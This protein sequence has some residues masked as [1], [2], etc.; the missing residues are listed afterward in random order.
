MDILEGLS[1][2]QKEAVQYGD[3]PLLL[4]AGAGSGKTRV[5]THRIAYLIQERGVSPTNI[6]AVTFTNKAAEEMKNRLQDL[7]GIMSS[8]LWVSTFHSSCVRILRD[9]IERL[10]YSRNFTIY[11]G[12]D[13]MML[14]KQVLNE[15][16]IDS[17]QVR[18]ASLLNAVSNAKNKLLNYEAY[19][20]TV[21][22]FF[23]QRA[24][25]A[26]KLYQRH[27]HENNALDF[28][29]L[30]MLTTRLFEECPEFLEFYQ[31][32]F[33]YILIDEYQDTNHAQYKIAR[34][35]AQKYKNICAIGDDDQSIYSWR[36]AD[37][38]NILD[39]ER[40]YENAAVFRLEQNYRSTQNIL[41]AAHNVV[42]NNRRRKEKELWTKNVEGEKIVC[43]GAI[44]EKGEAEYVTDLIKKLYSDG[45]YKYNDFAVFYRV[46]AQSRILE[47]A[48][49]IARL[50]YT[51]VGNLRFY[52]RQEIKDV[53]AYL[54][55]LINSK[56]AIS[57][58]RIINVP[59]RGI[60]KTTISRIED[61]AYEEYIPLYEALKKVEQITTLQN[62]AQKA[63]LK[64][65][66]IIENIDPDRK[67]SEVIEDVLEKSGYIKAL[68]EDGTVKSQSRIENAKE[69]LSEAKEFE[70]NQEEPTL[71][72]F[73]EGITLKSDIDSYEEQVDQV[74][75]MTLHNAKGLEFPVVFITGLEENMLPIWR[76]L[77][78]ES[79]ME[80]ERRLCYVG[81]TRAKQR[82]YLI[83][84][85]ERRLFGNVSNNEP[86]RFID[87]IPSEL[88]EVHRDTVAFS[89]PVGKTT[90]AEPGEL[91][92]EAETPFAE[93]FNYKTGDRVQHPKWGE[94]VVRKTSGRG[95]STLITVRFDSGI[96][97]NL[98]AEYAKL[99]KIIQLR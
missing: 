96:Q 54:R 28:D 27:L 75:L 53:I 89:P 63:V 15:L 16:Q 58:K 33:R 48:L 13:Q 7:V 61:F 3:G 70:E 86:S 84:A 98:M 90:A 99:E 49:R 4:L 23:E 95:R 46:N 59:T 69:L 68:K 51:I 31:E 38:R 19:A 8:M 35:L 93:D 5:L 21:G 77:E 41:N 52:E 10:G 37:I 45:D 83:S 25:D 76:S 78:N 67:P 22:S 55:L 20:N 56:D 2:I 43:Y 64:F 44:N 73:L 11:D 42:V 29:D 91:T 17:K 88:K 71:A 82:L 72:N 47:N 24:A 92:Y 94:G 30:L 85:A 18:P 81:I 39:F 34:S 50:P 74:S 87:E 12:T 6:L 9:D 62:R 60:G 14:M 57:L 65:I 66:E 36:G 32:K 80:E 79:E 97:K 1:E 26:Y 40:D